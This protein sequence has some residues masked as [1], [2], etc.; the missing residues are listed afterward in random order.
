MNTILV[1]TI[2]QFKEQYYSKSIE[3]QR[4]LFFSGKISS[5]TYILV[6]VLEKEDSFHYREM[7]YIPKFGKVIYLNLTFFIRS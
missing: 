2:T 5:H 6:D 1:D 3:E 7:E 4:Y